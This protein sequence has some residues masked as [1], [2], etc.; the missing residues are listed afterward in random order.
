MITLVAKL[1]FQCL[2]Y[3]SELRPT[4]N[5]VMEVLM[6]IKVV[7]RIDTYYNTKDLQTVNV[8]P[9]SETNDTIVLL[10]D[11]WRSPVFVTSPWQRNNSAS[12]TLNSNGDRFSKK[13]DGYIKKPR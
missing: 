12:T 11:F 7:G 3:D 10:K 5:E 13:N 4:M 2:Q 8:L 1:A 9:L 6:D